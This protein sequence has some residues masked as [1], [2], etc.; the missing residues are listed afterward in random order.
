[1]PGSL[2]TTMCI[3][4]IPKLVKHIHITK[5]IDKKWEHQ[6]QHQHVMLYLPRC[7]WFLWSLD[8][9]S[10]CHTSG[11]ITNCL[12]ASKLALWCLDQNLAET[13]MLQS[14][15]V[16]FLMYPCWRLCP[17]F[18]IFNKNRMTCARDQSCLVTLEFWVATWIAFK[19][20]KPNILGYS[21]DSSDQQ[22]H[23]LRPILLDPQL[24]FHHLHPG[25]WTSHFFG[26]Y[27]CVFFVKRTSNIFY[28]LKLTNI[29]PAMRPGPK[30]RLI[31]THPSVSGSNC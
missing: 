13:C 20:S 27:P 11:R 7:R 6:K 23:I 8:Y 21:L 9:N 30:R 15:L 3:P 17:L 18:R 1:M 25:A 2:Y 29:A 12:G 5:H 26:T 24:P 22:H 14:H 16:H 31:W 10:P 28:P 19:H 4:A